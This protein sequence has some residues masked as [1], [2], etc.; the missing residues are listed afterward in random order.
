MDTPIENT[1][2]THHTA[3]QHP[4]SSK[5]SR[6][7]IG[8]PPF[9]GPISGPMWKKVEALSSAYP[10]DFDYAIYDQLQRKF[11]ENQPRGGVVFKT[12]L[13]LVNHHSSCSKCHY[14]FELDTYGR[15]CT[16]NCVYCYA[17]EQLTAHGYWNRP[18]PFPVDFS[19]LRKIFA[20]VFESE[21]HSKWR[22]I[23]EARIPIRLGSMTDCFMKMD[24]KYRVTFELLKLL[25]FYQYPYIVFTRSD[26]IADDEYLGVLDRKLA[27][28]QVSISGNNEQLTKAIEP[29]APSVEARVA[30]LKKLAQH[31]FWTTVRINPLFPRYPDGYFTDHDVLRSRMG[32]EIPTFPFLDEDFVPLLRD[33]QV[34]SVLAGF[35][36]LSPVAV[37]QLSKA[38]G[39]DLKRFFD[40]KLQV[41][42]NDRKYS[43]REIAYYYRELHEQCKRHDIRFSTCFIGNGLKDYF[44]YQSLWSNK[45]DC[46]DARG[47]VPSFKASSQQIPWHTRLNHA[48]CTTS[49]LSTK[50]EEERLDDEYDLTKSDA[51]LPPGTFVSGSA[52][53]R[54]VPNYDA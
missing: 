15:G 29:G 3:L 34:P 30:A 36:R 37:H 41:R 53:E 21:R 48:P 18:H 19:E 54:Q 14:A 42:S 6:S 9:T 35:V 17:Y 52:P 39:I 27:S 5:I 26:L 12:T 31:G 20:T 28:I 1:A 51:I 23:L 16:A 25:R 46:C 49:A 40:P 8:A 13:R 24:R 47:N 43:D 50:A 2:V 11:G 44:Q 33:A 45:S 32:S 10:D 38:T 7:E 22:S 4:S